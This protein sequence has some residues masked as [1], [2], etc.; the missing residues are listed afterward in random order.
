MIILKNPNFSHSYLFHKGNEVIK[1]N[2]LLRQI[3]YFHKDSPFFDSIFLTDWIE[4]EEQENSKVLLINRAKLLH[5]HLSIEIVDD[6]ALYINTDDPSRFLVNKDGKFIQVDEKF[7]CLS[8]ESDSLFLQTTY[9]LD[10]PEIR[11]RIL[12]NSYKR[13]FRS[14]YECV[15]SLSATPKILH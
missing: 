3:A 6:T 14:Q 11:N 1:V 5:K 13:I 7:N 15:D 2:F 9:N 8:D 10:K 12:S 4:L